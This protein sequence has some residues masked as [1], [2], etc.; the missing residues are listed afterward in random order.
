MELKNCRVLV[1]PS[2]Y[3]KTDSRLLEE[4]ESLVGEV[5]YN[6]TGQPL[7]ST[8]VARLLHG[9]D[10]YIA[11]LDAIDSTSLEQADKLKVIARYGV[12]LDN[13]D[14]KA[15]TTKGIRVTNTPMANSV[16]V[17]E[18]TIGLILAL[19]RSIPHAIEA[20]RQGG[21]PRLTGLSLEYKTIGL[22]GIGAIGK[23]VVRRLSGF[24]CR[25]LGC[26][27][28]VNE[29]FA[30]TNN[31]IYSSRDQVINEANFLSLHLP[32]KPDT[33]NLVDADFLRKMKKGAYLINTSRGELID[34]NAL[35]N[36]IREGHLAGAALDVFS[37]EPPTADNPLLHLS[38][39]LVTPHCSS[40]T[41]G[42]MN[43]M[44]WMALR[45]CLAV[46]RG[47]EPVYPVN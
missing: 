35:V 14:L 28:V 7:P 34:E 19:A 41:D 40:H 11:G 24:N 27:P 2:S 43:T 44:G 10:G 21:W 6:S 17:A 8:E 45:D 26:D 33:R 15:A 20:T 5:I 29:E 13:V 31:L 4:L 46:L 9:I 36:A 25:I 18:L 38:N 3:G 42:A 30:M 32:L 47:E 23:Q 22:L 1:T 37:S 39:V 12:G 16:S